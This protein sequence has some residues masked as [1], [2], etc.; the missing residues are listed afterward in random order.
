[1]NHVY[2]SVLLT[3]W[4]GASREISIAPIEVKSML[5][6]AAG[7]NGLAASSRWAR[8][9]SASK[10]DR[11]GPDLR[12]TRWSRRVTCAKAAVFGQ[13]PG[14]SRGSGTEG[15]TR[16]NPRTPCLCPA[17]SVARRWGGEDPTVWIGDRL[18]G[19]E[20]G[21]EPVHGT[22]EGLQP[23]GVG[24]R[25][26]REQPVRAHPS[27]APLTSPWRR[28][29]PPPPLW[30]AKQQ[31]PSGGGGDQ[32]ERQFR[33]SDDDSWDIMHNG[34]VMGMIRGKV[35]VQLESG[36]RFLRSQQP[37]DASAINDGQDSLSLRRDQTTD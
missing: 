19:P 28:C 37:W 4:D 7:D 13:D 22:G 35:G 27:P 14:P 33:E 10:R 25:T 26:R 6:C 29:H 24:A 2:K 3:T 5:P 31:R 23:D 12:G 18:A 17:I 1:M 20:E 15:K 16:Q 21:L 9:T 36:S 11:W 8:L 32:D 30:H 34:V